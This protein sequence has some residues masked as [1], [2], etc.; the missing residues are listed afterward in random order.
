VEEHTDNVPVPPAL[1]G[2]YR[3][4]WELSSARALAVLHALGA[5][6]GVQPQRLA[7]VGL[8]E[9]HPV[10]SNANA[11]GRAQNRRVVIVIGDEKRP[12]VALR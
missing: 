8:G 3:T 9:H 2:R 5:E 1:Q 11:A 12:D 6:P 4:N 7:A 10:G